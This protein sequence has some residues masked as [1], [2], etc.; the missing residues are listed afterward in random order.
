MPLSS[1]YKEALNDIGGQSPLLLLEITHPD[2]AAPVRIV[3][4]N[5]DLVSNGNTFLAC[6]FRAALPDDISQGQPRATLAIDNVGSVLTQ[7]I[8]SSGGGEGAQVRMMQALRSDPDTLEIDITLGITDIKMNAV[9]V[10]GTLS[11]D[12]LLNMPG[13][14]MQF[15]PENTPGLY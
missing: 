14:A 11:Y 2:L 6:A 4:D 8:E 9:E 10:T 7:W 15:R 3:N 5:Q 12:D 1:T 13:I